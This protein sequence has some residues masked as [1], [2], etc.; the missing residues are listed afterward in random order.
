MLKLRGKGWIQKLNRSARYV[1]TPRGMTQGTTLVKFNECLN[2]TLGGPL[3][4]PIQVASPQ[5]EVQKRFRQVRNSIDKLL[6]TAGM[7]T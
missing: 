4:D 6:E 1:I 3:T 2:G 5:T 7:A